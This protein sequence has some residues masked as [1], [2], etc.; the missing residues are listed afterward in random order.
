MNYFNPYL[1]VF[2]RHNHDIKCILSGKAAK[3]AM[4]YITDYITQGDLNTHEMLSLLSH[5]VA[6]LSDSPNENDSPLVRSKRLLHKCLSQFTRQQQIH[7]QQAARYLRGED[8]S[9]PSHKTVSMLSALLISCVMKAAHVKRTH[10]G[11]THEGDRSGDALDKDDEN[12][13][14]ADKDDESDSETN[15][16]HYRDREREDISLKIVLNRDGTLCETNQVVDYLYRGE[17]LHSMAFYN[18]C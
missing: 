14:G 8:D 9:I 7:M 3:A 11:I 1:L 13:V 18:F 15:G 5:A 12:C 2:C 6:N 17:S 10:N 4:F 16:D